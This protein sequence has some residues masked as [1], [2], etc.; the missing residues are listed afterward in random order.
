[1]AIEV[2]KDSKLITVLAEQCKHKNVNPEDAKQAAEIIA[3]L[4]KDMSPENLHQIAQVFTYTLN[5]LQSGELN[6]LDAV[7][8]TKNVGEGDKVFFRVKTGGIKAFYQ[9]KGATTARSYV[10]ERQFTM[11]TE[12]IST[13]PAIN[14]VDL[15]TGRVNMADLIQEANHVISQMKLKK[16]EQV[17]HSA[18]STF[19]SPFYAS[20][21]G[22]VKS[23]LD[24]Q[25]AYFKRLGPVT[26]IGDIAAVSQL[27]P[28]TGM[29]MNAGTATDQFMQ[30]PD[31]MV[32]EYN[33]NGFIGRY[34]GCAVVAMQN[35]FEDDSTT[36]LLNPD[37]LY[38]VVGGVSNDDKN[39]KILNEGQL[40]VMESQNIDDQTFEMRFD[41]GFGCAF[42]NGKLP[43]CGAY[44][45]L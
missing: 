22:I 17:L 35:G 31:S 3:E 1:M 13:R 26:I 18:I 12:N 33:N 5:R 37:W 42:I 21:T 2:K 8:D 45:I 23:T 6:F 24:T 36:L 27:A 14:I 9:A 34:N 25:L 29:A 4:T 40:S 44:E 20:G 39:L 30:R 28:L 16:V 19:T 38:I 10:S 15:R 32:D 7:A 43:R 11:N 41:Q